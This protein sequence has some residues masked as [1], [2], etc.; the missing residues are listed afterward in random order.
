MFHSDVLRVALLKL[1]GGVY[2]D[3]DAVSIR[4]LPVD[5]RNFVV[6]E[7]SESIANGLLKFQLDHPVIKQVL[8]QLGENKS[9]L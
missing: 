9:D 1:Y 8:E 6:I 3:S 7:T 2:L 5:D 4:P